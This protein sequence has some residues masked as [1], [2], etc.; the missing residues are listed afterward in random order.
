MEPLTSRQRLLNTLNGQTVDRI[1]ISL[2]EFD[3]YYESWIHQEPEYQAILDY[4]QGKTDRLFSWGPKS[5][6]PN[7]F[8]GGIDP[9]NI[10][11]TT[12]TEANSSFIKTTLQTPGG[13]LITQ[14]RQDDGVHTR[15][16]IEHYCKTAADAE[17]VLS[18]PYIPWKPS[19]ASFFE[20]E[21][22]LGNTGIILGDIPDPL[23]LTV[24]LF[25]FSK[26]L[27]V[28]IDNPKLIFR[29]LDFF[30]ERIEQY[31]KHLLKS[32][33]VTLYRI[34]GPEYAT[35]PYL[36]PAD[37]DKLVTP[38]VIELIKRIHRYSAKARVH[39]HGKIKKVLPSFARM[40][41]D[42][43]DPLEPPPDGDA[44]LTEVRE[45]LGKKVVLIGNIEERLFEVGTKQDIETAVQKAVDEGANNG[46]FILCPT[47]MPLT[48]PLDSAIC[49]KIIHYID[50][51][52]KYGKKSC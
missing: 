30:H 14:S 16:I 7:I 48:T 10:K 15:W 46:P 11:I 17:K 35:P 32:G 26:F 31:L 34:C 51:G 28:Y 8:F 19:I 52:L 20:L 33:A 23:C 4:A 40:N 9:E 25:G 43:I 44:E 13:E 27:M 12:W 42:A 24:D 6:I 41:L 22:K 50:C 2:Y 47:A 21:K 38:Y 37:F 18:I 1:P 5:D 3:G 49:E 39:S 36:S 45:A 29:L